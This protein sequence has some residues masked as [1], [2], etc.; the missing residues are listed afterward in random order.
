MLLLP[1]LLLA[2]CSPEQDFPPRVIE[3]R[4]F[5]ED[6]PRGETLMKRAL[7]TMHNTAR[8]SAR[9]PELAWDDALARDATAY[10]RE[11]ARRGVFEHSKQPRGNPPQGENL[12]TGT[13][14]AYRYDEMAQHWIDEQR[15]FVN[16]PIPNVSRSG[17]FGDVGHYTQIVW[18]STTRVG[19]GFASNRRDDY[20]VCRYTPAG[21][22]FGQRA[23]P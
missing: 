14:G 9:V 17:K 3:P 20:L 6:A 5:E 22:V 19:C 15:F 8:L 7:L 21:N 23:L 4:R 12:W 18:R 2:A 13:H 16:N 1:L 10:A 11:L